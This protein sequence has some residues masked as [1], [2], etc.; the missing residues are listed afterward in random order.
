MVRVK[1]RQHDA[2]GHRREADERAAS[3]E[4]IIAM[5]ARSHKA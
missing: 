1:I 2:G 3:K 4:S 5:Q